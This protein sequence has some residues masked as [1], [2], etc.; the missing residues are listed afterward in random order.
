MTRKRRATFSKVHT[1][2]HRHKSTRAMH[3]PLYLYVCAGEVE[4]VPMTPT[5]EGRP[6]KIT[7]GDIA[8][9]PKGLGCTWKVTKAVRKHYQF[10]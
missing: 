6:V 8:I 5:G 4:V 10:K 1:S 3:L 9:F 7:A 2:P